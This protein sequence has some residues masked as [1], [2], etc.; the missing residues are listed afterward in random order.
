VEAEA[1]PSGSGGAAVPLGGGEARPRQPRASDSNERRDG[2]VRG[3]ARPGPAAIDQ[4][5]RAGRRGRGHRGQEVRAAA[6]G[7]TL[8]WGFWPRDPEKIGKEKK[9]RK[10]V[11]LAVAEG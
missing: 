9:Y 3:R 11:V 5:K 2:E 1:D 10:A 4:E 6:G 8:G 7:G